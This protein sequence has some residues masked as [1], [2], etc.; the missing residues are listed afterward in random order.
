[1]DSLSSLL[2]AGSEF[3]GVSSSLYVHFSRRFEAVRTAASSKKQRVGNPFPPRCLPIR[4]AA[5]DDKA[6]A[7]FANACINRYFFLAIRA[8]LMG[9][10]CSRW[11]GL[12][13]SSAKINQHDANDNDHSQQPIDHAETPPG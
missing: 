4:S 6:S 12:S 11:H 5:I 7:I 8:L 10:G 2:N 13:P 3:D 9:C 1:M